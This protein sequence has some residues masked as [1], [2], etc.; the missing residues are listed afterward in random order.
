MLLKI[1]W[2]TISTK[3]E[4]ILKY[5]LIFGDGFVS[6]GGLETTQ[7]IF[8]DEI[9]PTN[10]FANL[11]SVKVLDIGCGIGGGAE[12]IS[13]NI[14]N[15]HVL[16]I[17]F[18]NNSL[19]IAKE[20]YEGNPNLSFKFANALEIEF[21]K[22]SFNLIYSRDAIMHIASKDVLF[23][24]MYDFTKPN[25]KMLIT[26]Y[27][28]GEQ[29]NWSPEFIEYVK[30]R[31][32]NLPTVAQYKEILE[33][34]GWTVERAEDSTEWFIQVMKD[35]IHKMNNTARREEFLKKFSEEELSDLLKGWEQKIVRSNNGEQKWGLFI[36]KKVEKMDSH[37]FA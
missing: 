13:K 6:T 10:T 35:E 9:F 23:K 3:K 31:G 2:R 36:C 28:G 12:Y 22:E 16:G 14:P 8:S 21:D 32:Y 27:I 25:G 7:K 30:Q 20:R 5:E 26:D 18:N 11:D 15:S 19:S 4:G 33:K 34:A 17:D 29:A 37:R 1:F 24:R